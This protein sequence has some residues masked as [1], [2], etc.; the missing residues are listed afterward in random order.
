MAPRQHPWHC[1]QSHLTIRG[2]STFSKELLGSLIA[3]AE[4]KC[5]ELQ[6]NLETAQA[7]YDEGKAV[8]A[9][10]NAQ[11]DDIISWAEMY[12]TAS[13]EAKK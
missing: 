12:D 6:E 5:R 3:E 7:A 1:L 13:M 11:Y 2:E 10:L 8:L 4:A 9:S